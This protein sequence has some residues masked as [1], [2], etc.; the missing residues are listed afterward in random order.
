MSSTELVRYDA[1]CHAIAAAYEVRAST[2]V[3]WR[4]PIQR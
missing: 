2:S 1:M 3:S 4:Y